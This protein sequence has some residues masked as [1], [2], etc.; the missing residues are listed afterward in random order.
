M[1]IQG[2]MWVFDDL[3]DTQT[4]YTQVG[5][6]YEVG[7]EPNGNQKIG[8][9]STKMVQPFKKLMAPNRGKSSIMV[10]HIHKDTCTVLLTTYCG[11]SRGWGWG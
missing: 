5:D 3:G 9:W 6:F 8:F 11:T 4:I 10:N 1:S 7:F 2:M